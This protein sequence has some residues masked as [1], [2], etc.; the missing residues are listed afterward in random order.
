MCIS[1][2]L[3]SV[4]KLR[5]SLQRIQSSYSIWWGLQFCLSLVTGAMLKRG[6]LIH[7]Q[8]Y[9][10]MRLAMEEKGQ[11]LDLPF[12][13]RDLGSWGR[14]T[15]QTI[16]HVASQGRA[17]ALLLAG[18][19]FTSVGC[20]WSLF[21]AIIC[22]SEQSI[23]TRQLGLPLARTS[24]ECLCMSRG[25]QRRHQLTHPHA[26]T[27]SNRYIQAHAQNPPF[28]HAHG[29]WHKYVQGYTVIRDRWTDLEA[30]SAPS[31]FDKNI[32]NFNYIYTIWSKCYIQ[33][34]IISWR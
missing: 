9:V 20:C 31:H 19:V 30:T 33:Y 17:A 23:R 24:L 22:R 14:R 4:H 13:L 28:G 1:L 18:E 2:L 6:G 27:H 16:K 11:A 25:A 32:S 26:H 15:P 7:F 5:W 21:R 29:Y 34:K 8:G 12:S 3:N 10:W